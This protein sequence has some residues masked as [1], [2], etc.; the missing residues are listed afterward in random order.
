MQ[1]KK[2]IFREV[3]SFLSRERINKVWFACHTQEFPPN[4]FLVKF[5]RLIVVLEGT[6]KTNLGINGKSTT[7]TINPGEVIYIPPQ[8]WDLPDWNT[9]A[10]AITFLFGHYQIGMSL[11][12]SNCLEKPSSVVK[13]STPEPIQQEAIYLEKALH[14]LAHTSAVSDAAPCIAEGL[15]RY[16]NAKI[17]QQKENIH[18]HA[19]DRW[20][21]ICMYLQKNF[22]IEITRESVAM[23]YGLSPNHLSRLFREEGSIGFNEYLTLV[24]IDRAKML[25]T[26]YQMNMSEI[27]DRTGFKDSSYL[28][29]VFRKHTGMTPGGYRARY[30][31]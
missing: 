20:R 1:E 12:S 15:L 18:S 14:E 17:E 6:Y 2:T 27:A 28:G 9:Q 13:L 8:T 11:T 25:L 22:G 4:A 24:R 10:K 31:V 23:E 30:A 3:D 21:A 7:I 26:Q 19:S 5:S 29:R 16:C